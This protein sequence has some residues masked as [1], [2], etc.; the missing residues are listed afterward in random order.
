MLTTNLSLKLLRATNITSQ[1][2]YKGWSLSN[3][4][5]CQ[6]IN[7]W[8]TQ[9]PDKNMDD[10]SYMVHEIILQSS[11]DLLSHVP[12][13]ETLRFALFDEYIKNVSKEDKS[14][15]LLE[16]SSKSFRFKDRKQSVRSTAAIIPTNIDLHKVS[17]KTYIR[18]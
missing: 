12:L 6:C 8:A 3:K 5:Y 4:L 1:T 17:I 11:N 10:V 14:K 7:H 13:S 18:D 15:V 9:C 2:T 16:E